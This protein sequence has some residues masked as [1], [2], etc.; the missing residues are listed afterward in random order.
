[1]TL[2]IATT[3]PEGVIVTA[4][5]RQ[6]YVN[7]SNMPR[8]ASDN[9]AK[10][11]TL[12]D[13][14]AVATAGPAFFLDSGRQRAVQSFVEEFR[15]TQL[16]AGKTKA[17]KTCVHVANA[18]DTF[19]QQ[20]LARVGEEGIRQYV[21]T[22]SGATGLIIASRT[23][24]KLPYEFVDAG[25]TTVKNEWQM[26]IPSFVFV[27]RDPDSTCHAI[28]LLPF[29]GIGIHNTSANPLMLWSGQIEVLNKL[30]TGPD[31]FV[32]STATMTIQDAVDFSI[33]LTRTT[34]KLQKFSDGTA[35]AQ[36]GIPGVGGP[37]DVLYVPVKGKL[38]WLAQKTLHGEEHESS[39]EEL[40][41]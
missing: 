39:D 15:D 3:N 12:S 35:T 19:C 33:L 32:I 41:K 28:S 25:G 6:T 9:A 21:A 16:K 24:T 37:I 31:A 7:R 29:S 27:G 36:G 1:M 11:I 20:W 30:L 4:D 14:M 13:T 22:Q 18:F 2:I 8:V 40:R 5:S 38:R 23:G 26:A 34:E 10:I 17:L